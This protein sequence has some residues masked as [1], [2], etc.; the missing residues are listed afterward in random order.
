MFVMPCGRKSWDDKF[1]CV[2]HSI[3]AFLSLNGTKNTRNMGKKVKRKCIKCFYLL[4]MFCRTPSL[5]QKRCCFYFSLLSVSEGNETFKFKSVKHFYC[6]HFNF[7]QFIVDNL[8]SLW[9]K[10]NLKTHFFLIKTKYKKV[11]RVRLTFNKW[12]TQMMKD[13][14]LRK[15]KKSC[16]HHRKKKRN[17][18]ETKANVCFTR[19]LWSSAFFCCIL[20]SFLWI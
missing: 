9:R 13:K 10:N 11:E 12:R 14:Q 8:W 3:V 4:F 20:F 1:A 2:P 18:I 7:H 16:F 6:L 5:Q 15:K 17:I 19:A